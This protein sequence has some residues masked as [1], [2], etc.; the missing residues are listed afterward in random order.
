[1]K[2]IEIYNEKAKEMYNMISAV[3]EECV[4]ANV[5]TKYGVF[6]EFF[7]HVELVRV[8]VKENKS[9]ISLVVFDKDLY[10][11]V[12]EAK[13]LTAANIDLETGRINGR[14]AT[15]VGIIKFLKGLGGVSEEVEQFTAKANL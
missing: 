7:G 8:Y 3:C 6:F 2:G 11:N 12:V 5:R 14:L 10:I 13:K 15:M 9:S 1:M 4:A